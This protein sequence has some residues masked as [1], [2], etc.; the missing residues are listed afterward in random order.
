MR[1]NKKWFTE[2]YEQFKTL[3]VYVLN[4]ATKRLIEDCYKFGIIVHVY[5]DGMNEEGTK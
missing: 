4:S 2:F 5:P 3:N 1:A